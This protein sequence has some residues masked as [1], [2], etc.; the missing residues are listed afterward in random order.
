VAVLETFFLVL[1]AVT[2]GFIAWFSAY[3]VYKLYQ[4]QR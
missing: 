3:S 2:F 4:G 1:L